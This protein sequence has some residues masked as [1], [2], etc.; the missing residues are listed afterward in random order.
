MAYGMQ[1]P[2]VPFPYFYPTKI[3]ANTTALPKQPSLNTENNFNPK[4]LTPLNFSTKRDNNQDHPQRR[5]SSPDSLLAASPLPNHSPASSTTG[6]SHSETHHQLHQ[7]HI[8][9][10]PQQQ[11]QQHQTGQLSSEDASDIEL[12]TTNGGCDEN[13]NVEI[14]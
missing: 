6:R 3:P 1:I 7:R 11:Q 14:D 4:L 9:D 12:E 13:E 5:R 8:Y 2:Q 10:Q